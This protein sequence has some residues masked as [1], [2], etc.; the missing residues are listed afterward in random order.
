MKWYTGQ[1]SEN[2]EICFNT[3]HSGSNDLLYGY[4]TAHSHRETQAILARLQASRDIRIHAALDDIRFRVAQFDESKSQQDL[5]VFMRYLESRLRDLNNKNAAV[6]S[7]VNGQQQ[8]RTSKGSLTNGNAR[9]YDVPDSIS[10]KSRASSTA[11]VA[12][13]ETPPVAPRQMG[14]QH[15]RSSGN[16]DLGG[17]NG[18]EPS[19]PPRRT[20][21]SSGN[22][23]ECVQI[24]N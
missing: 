6:L 21:Q 5:Q 22:Q 12:S 9:H 13:R 16:I 10:M 20:S 15:H 1:V 17:A 23:G 14:R 11:N 2:S 18:H 19:A 3:A 8:R 7:D 24:T 4:I